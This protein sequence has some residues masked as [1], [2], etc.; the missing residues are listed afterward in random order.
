MATK[1]WRELTKVQQADVKKRLTSPFETFRGNPY[2]YEVEG[3][4]VLRR[5]MHYAHGEL[6]EMRRFAKNPWRD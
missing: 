5:R 6:D 3:G 4:K 1:R 2:D